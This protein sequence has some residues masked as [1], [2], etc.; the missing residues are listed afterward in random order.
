MIDKET[1]TNMVIDKAGKIM[2]NISGDGINV[3]APITDFAT[4]NKDKINEN[5]NNK[6][7]HSDIKINLK[8]MIVFDN[9]KLENFVR[10]EINKTDKREP[11]NAYIDFVDGKYVIIPEDNGNIPQN[12]IATK[13]MD[14]IK[15]FVF[16]VNIYDL[17]GYKKAEITKENEELL[18]VLK[19]YQKFE[20]F[21]LTYK[22]GDKN[23][24]LDIEMIYSWLLPNYEENSIVLNEEAPF[25][26]DVGK[27]N[28]YIEQI[29]TTHK[30][31]SEDTFK[32]SNGKSIVYSNETSKT[33]LDEQKLKDDIIEHI[34]QCL[35]EEKELPYKNEPDI[36][37]KTSGKIEDTYIE[38]SIEEQKIWMYID[39][40]LIVESDIV[41]G[42][43]AKKHFTRK[44]VFNLTYKTKNATLRGPGYASFV[45][46]WMP[47]DGGIGLHDATWRDEFGGDIYLTDGSHGCVNL[48]KE[49]AKTIYENITKEMP[50]IVW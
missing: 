47:F 19:E 21:V 41:T 42:N 16:D 28:D 39:G 40:E 43:I 18:K 29:K 45:Y 8:E 24:K 22:I 6:Y 35:S 20:N 13:I 34:L 15:N 30:L 26:V 3:S 23:E 27:V 4:I 7:M 37:N 5:L 32:T 44:G 1:A 10:G 17:D 12:D 25:T 48:P 2:C 46:Y 33:W 9:E 31:N 36:V 14:N 50:I 49:T 11:Q 38:I